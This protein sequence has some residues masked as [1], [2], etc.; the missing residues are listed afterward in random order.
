MVCRPRNVKKNV[1]DGEELTWLFLFAI[2][3]ERGDETRRELIP[4]ETSFAV[5]FTVDVN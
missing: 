4:L 3:K 2:C 1:L 5:V